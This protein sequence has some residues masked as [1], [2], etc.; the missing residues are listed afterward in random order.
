MAYMT[1]YLLANVGGVAVIEFNI[2]YKRL[3]AALA[4]AFSTV[5]QELPI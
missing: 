2:E 1:Q 4:K 3:T 5:L